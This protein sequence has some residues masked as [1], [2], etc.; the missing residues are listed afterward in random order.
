[1]TVTSIMIPFECPEGPS[2]MPPSASNTLTRT[3][4]C[5]GAGM[6][7]LAE[8]GCLRPDTRTLPALR[9]TQWYSLRVYYIITMYST[10]VCMMRASNGRGSTLRLRGKCHQCSFTAVIENTCKCSMTT[11]SDQLEKWR[12]L[13]LSKLHRGRCLAVW[14]ADVWSLSKASCGPLVDEEA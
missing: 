11:C 6:A 10:V 8:S 9:D 7:A 14:R 5:L 1:M 2:E 4:A 12:L 3:L 13:V